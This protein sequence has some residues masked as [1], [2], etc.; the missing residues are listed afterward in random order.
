MPSQPRE[1]LVVLVLGRKCSTAQVSTCCSR[2]TAPLRQ[3]A[4]PKHA[5]KTAG[6]R[7]C[8]N[9]RPISFAPAVSQRHFLL[10]VIIR[11]PNMVFTVMPLKHFS[12]HPT[13]RFKKVIFIRNFQNGITKNPMNKGKRIIFHCTMSSDLAL[14]MLCVIF[15][16]P[17]L[18]PLAGIS[19]LLALISVY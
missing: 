9:R 8:K 19:C 16:E 6:E 12:R 1:I 11:Q 2:K 3:L 5:T 7:N 14:I 17:P 4:G 13:Q 18:P 15:R 10:V